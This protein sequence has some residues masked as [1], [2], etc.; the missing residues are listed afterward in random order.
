MRKQK[1]L[2]KKLMGF[3]LTLVMICTLIPLAP[4][5]VKAA[6]DGFYISGTSV[7]DANGNKFVMRGVNIAHAWYTS[8]TD[9]SIKAAASKG[10]NCVRIVCSNGKQYTKTSASEL[11]H[12]I[13]VCKQ[14]K[15]V[16][17][18][19]VHDATGSDSTSD[20]NAAVDYWKEMKS[21]LSAN[22][23]YVIV[24]IAN[25]WYGTWNA[26]SYTHLT[27]PTRDQV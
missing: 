25:E 19:E 22:K 10:A 26:V 8:E 21:I 16:C 17:I 2:T 14:N 7:Y 23:K 13:D 12:I 9:T 3:L 27:L 11:Q 20:L 18:V 6:S 15:V 5:T 1:Q 4:Q 24:N